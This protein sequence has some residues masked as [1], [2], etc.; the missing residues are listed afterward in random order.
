MEKHLWRSLGKKICRL[1]CVEGEVIAS[2]DSVDGMP[3]ASREE[4]RWQD[5]HDLCFV[6]LPM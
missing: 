1:L 3:A 4:R 2:Q 5:G 6:L